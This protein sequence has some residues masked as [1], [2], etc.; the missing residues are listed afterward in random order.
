VRVVDHKKGRRIWGSKNLRA[1][2]GE[3]KRLHQ[4]SDYLHQPVKCAF[5][6]GRG[7]EARAW[8]LCTFP[9]LASR[10]HWPNVR[11]ISAQ[12]H[13][14][15]IS[16]LNKVHISLSKLEVRGMWTS[17]TQFLR[18]CSGSSKKLLLQTRTD[19]PALLWFST[20]LHV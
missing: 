4:V 19:I 6:A 15:L 7:Q 20:S 9:N 16:G 2:C 12:S 17:C 8:L 5:T 10:L 11:Y 3:E 18:T 13:E 1:I 14:M